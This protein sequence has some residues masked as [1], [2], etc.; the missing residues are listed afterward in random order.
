LSQNLPVIYYIPANNKKHP[1]V[2]TGPKE[3]GDMIQY[4]FKHRTTPVGPGSD[5]FNALQKDTEED[6]LRKRREFEEKAAAEFD[7]EADSL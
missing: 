2:Y 6:K 4:L 7:A 3:T 5:L 1:E